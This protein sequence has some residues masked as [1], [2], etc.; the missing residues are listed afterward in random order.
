MT[1]VIPTKYRHIESGRIV[2]RLQDSFW[3]KKTLFGIKW[4]PAA[5]YRVE[6]GTIYS[7]PVTEF[8]DK[9]TSLI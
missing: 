6:D 4:I 9:F 7:R 5:S 8:Y 2:E 3:A 1:H